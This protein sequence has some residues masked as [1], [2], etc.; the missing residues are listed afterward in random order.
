MLIEERNILEQ[1]AL[2]V[3]PELQSVTGSF[4]PSIRAE[5]GYSGLTI[6]GH[7]HLGVLMY[8]RGPTRSGA[9]RSEPSLEESILAWINRHNIQ[10]KPS[11]NGKQ[12][13]VEKLA[14]LIARSIHKYGTKLY[15]EIQRGGQPRDPFGAIITESR[16]DAMLS[17]ITDVYEIRLTSDMVRALTRTA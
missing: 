11:D 13:T 17:Q 10:P 2:A 15:Q 12:I 3:I 4:G 5:V 16:I 1:F 6:D 14:F 8:G 9:G 7:P